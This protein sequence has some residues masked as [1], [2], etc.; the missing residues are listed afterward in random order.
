MTD[1]REPRLAPVSLPYD[2][3]I[4]RLLT[5]LMPPDAHVDPLVLFRVLAVHRD[6]ADRLR[7]MASGLLNKG[8]LPARDREV[9]ICRTT[10]RADA[11]YEWGVHAS[12]FG[13]AVGRTGS[14]MS[15]AL[16][17]AS[18]AKR[19]IDQVTIVC[20]SIRRPRTRGAAPSVRGTRSPPPQLSPRGAVPPVPRL[21]RRTG[22]SSP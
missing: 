13:S 17:M 20:A 6:L 21:V 10:A 12:F 9:F 5:K 3:D 7:P 22:R 14:S 16:S 18:A 1:I 8:L 4:A 15:S 19:R 11:E 2:E